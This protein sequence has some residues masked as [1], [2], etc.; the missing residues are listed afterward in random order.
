MLVRVFVGK[1]SPCGEKQSRAVSLEV[2]G[3]WGKKGKRGT[4]LTP[5]CLSSFLQRCMSVFSVVLFLPFIFPTSPFLA[6]F[7]YPSLQTHTHTH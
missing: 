1:T 2:S 6:A 5:I 3:C 7:S 4:F